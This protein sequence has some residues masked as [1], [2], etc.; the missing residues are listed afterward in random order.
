MD[1]ETPAKTFMLERSHEKFHEE[2]DPADPGQIGD[3]ENSQS[4]TFQDWDEETI[5]Q[6]HARYATML[7][8]TSNMTIPGNQ[9]LHAGDKVK[10]YLRD[11]RPD[12]KTDVDSYDKELSGHYLIYKMRQYYSMVPKKEC[13]SALTLVRD[14]L[15][16]NC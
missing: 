7:M 11:S 16:K 12:A 3:G 10:I 15:N 9:Y 5:V 1:S 8:S 14:T 6:Y 13:Y 4:A 2:E